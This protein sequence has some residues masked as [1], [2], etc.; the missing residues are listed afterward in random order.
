M[1]RPYV[2]IMAKEPRVGSTKTRLSPPLSP[3]DASR[4]YEAML[5]DTISLI[6]EFSG[7]DLAIAVTPP[8][9]I[10]YFQ[11]ITPDDT[12]Y[13]PVAC[14]DIGD[15][16]SQSLGSLLEMGSP[17]AMALNSDGPSL[18][19]EYISQALQL[20]DHF[21]V[22]LG[23][24]EDGGYYLIGIKKTYPE[25]FSDIEWST[26]FVFDQTM[27]KTEELGLTVGLLPPWYDV[28]TAA[29][30]D[31]LRT[32]LVTLP[33]GSLQHTRIVLDQIALDFPVKGHPKSD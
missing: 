26:S 5:Q 2:V 20:L 11:G 9:S 16:L 27:I 14:R 13:L 15:C 10:Q 17:K 32:E 12:L 8:E 30:I 18:P 19:G 22:V 33:P 28:D 21:D 4:L 1:S 6:S 3:V 24:S 25:L 7:L 23:P 31:R 29:D